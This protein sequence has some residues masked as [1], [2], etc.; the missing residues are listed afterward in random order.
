MVK[1]ELTNEEEN[2][3]RFSIMRPFRQGSLFEYFCGLPLKVLQA[4]PRKG[5]HWWLGKAART[6]QAL[7][8]REYILHWRMTEPEIRQQYP[9]EYLNS[10]SV[11]ELWALLRMLVEKVPVWVYEKPMKDAI[12]ILFRKM[13][14]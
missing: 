12:D 8:M 10:L 3:L 7:E 2:R 1:Y 9:R 4:Y 11:E 6:P 5:Y 13:G 14:R